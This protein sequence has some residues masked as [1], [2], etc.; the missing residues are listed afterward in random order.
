M[1]IRQAV[2]FLGLA[3]SVLSCSS[4]KL[5]N[6][7]ESSAMKRQIN[8][9]DI[10]A[11]NENITHNG[12]KIGDFELKE[13]WNTTASTIHLKLDRFARDNGANVMVVRTIGWGK[14]GNGFYAEGSLYYAA[15][16]I[17]ESRKQPCSI[18]LLRDGSES[19]LGSAFTIK[20]NINGED[21]GELTSSNAIQA[22]S[23]CFGKTNLTL[24]NEFQQISYNGKPR[25]FRAGKIT[26]QPLG[27]A[28]IGIA[29]GGVAL[30]EIE[31]ELIARLMMYQVGQ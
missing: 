1:K 25:Y 10:I 5:T 28:V 4:V 12:V 16:P 6:K 19:L 17:P 27:G 8:V 18:V 23:N 30:T 15:A 14:K 2:F 24:N 31:D 3:A 29:L 9:V 7:T 11:Q 26:G 20:V 22:D 21:R 13:D